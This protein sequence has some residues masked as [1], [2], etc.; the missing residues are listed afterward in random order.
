M[1]LFLKP[2]K[3]VQTRTIRMRDEWGALRQYEIIEGA[4]HFTDQDLA[5]QLEV[6]L[7]TVLTHRRD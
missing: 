1:F 4:P 2:R 7:I 6:E 5:D 3:E